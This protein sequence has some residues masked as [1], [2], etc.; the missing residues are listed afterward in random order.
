MLSL[1][2]I[3]MPEQME[4]EIVIFITASNED[5]AARIAHSLV[6]ARLAACANIVNNIRSIYKWKGSV[7]DDTEVLMIVKTRKSLFSAI[8][9]KVRELHSYDVPEIIALPIIDGSP[10]YLNWLK[11]STE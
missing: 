9:V 2:N 5:E 10:D 3:S 7:Q 8:S 11:E 6:E 1:Q 4:K